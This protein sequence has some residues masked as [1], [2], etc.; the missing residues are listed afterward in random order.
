MTFLSPTA[1]RYV[2]AATPARRIVL[3]MALLLALPFAF[4]VQPARAAAPAET[5]I[6]T[7]VQKGL[8][9]L[10]NQTISDTQRKAQFRTF[11][12]GL[13][14]LNRIALFTLGPAKRTASDADKAAFVDAFRDFAISIYE[15]RLTSYSG[16]TLKITGSQPTQK[17]D[18][19]VNTTLVD[20]H[21]SNNQPLPVAFRV[22]NTDGKM[23]VIDVN[24]LGVWLAI[25]ERDQFSSFLGDHGN[26]VP[27]LV[28][29]LKDLT[30]QMRN[31]APL[32]S[33]QQ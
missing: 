2:K 26:S 13:T 3:M 10:A 4:S 22:S 18:T 28:A 27:A 9:I 16:Q 19:I 33:P 30:Q 11:L 24:V 1:S 21:A 8:A 15:T 20:P 14:D 32:P 7:N 25:E 29:H 23:V 31:G 17:G 12:L 6:D 5:F